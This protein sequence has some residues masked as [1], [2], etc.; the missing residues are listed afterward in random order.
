LDEDTTTL[1]LDATI[2]ASVGLA[3]A[4]LD[5]QLAAIQADTDNIQTRIPAALVG[6]RIDAS[7]G[8]MAANTLTASA[9]ATDAVNEIVDQ[10]WEEAIADHSGTA[11]STAAALAAASS[12]GDPWGTALPGAY[13]AGTA[14]FIVGNNLDAPIS[15]V[16]T[17]TEN[18][19]GLLNRD[20][21]TG[22]DSGSTTV[23][24]PRQAFRILRNKWTI[25]SDGL[26]TI[27][28]EDDTTASWTQQLATDAS[29][30]P[31]V[32]TDPA[33]P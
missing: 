6:G 12:A 13:G 17:A 29:A 10:V 11:G 28:K 23:R 14:G 27:T 19:D 25:D 7:V 2:R 30:T 31:V 21:S 8:A 3:T 22:A 5:T 26:Q 18:A 15:D 4:N 9:L 33:G 24:T 32:G 16:P 1:D 20:M